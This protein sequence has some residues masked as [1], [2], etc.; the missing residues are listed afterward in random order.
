M[1]Q[2]NARRRFLGSVLVAA[3]LSGSCGDGEYVR[4]G[5]QGGAAGEAGDGEIDLVPAV[6]CDGSEISLDP[7]IVRSCVLNVSC[8]PF[9]PIDTISVCVSLNTQLTYRSTD[10]RDARSCADVT[11]C[12]G[13]GR[14]AALCEGSTGGWRCVN[15]QAV[16]CALNFFVDCDAYGGECQLYDD[17]VEGNRARCVVVPTCSE[18]AGT[19]QCAPGE[20]LYE[21]EDGVGFGR[22]CSLYG[23]HCTDQGARTSC[24]DDLPT[25][26]GDSTEC[27]GEVSS[28]CIDGE[29]YQADCAS[30]GLS[31]DSDTTYCLAPGCEASDWDSCSETCAGSELTLCYGGAPYTVD[32]RDFGFAG[33][34]NFRRGDGVVY[35]A[36]MP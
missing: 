14:D 11:A 18:S 36:C 12:T 33:C 34:T 26:D 1:H 27:V 30:V 24:Q 35:A 2:R 25:C 29:L 15:N 7:S 6:G 16:N 19:Y 23:G 5:D 20:R 8:S 21:C 4:G 17:P 10:C 31:C 22:D 3:C 28:Q 32:C 13:E 9:D